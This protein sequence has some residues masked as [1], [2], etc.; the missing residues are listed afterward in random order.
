[1]TDGMDRRLRWPCTAPRAGDTFGV[2]GSQRTTVSD[3]WVS[4]SGRACP[5]PFGGF[6]QWKECPPEIGGLLQWK[7]CPGGVV[8]LL[9]WKGL[10][11]EVWFASYSAQLQRRYVHLGSN[12]IPRRTYSR[13]THAA[14]SVPC[15]T[16]AVW[17]SRMSFP[18]AVA[19]ASSCAPGLGLNVVLCGSHARKWTSLPT[20][21]GIRTAQPEMLTTR[22]RT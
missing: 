18:G 20:S 16:Y 12:R 10:P 7:A 13:T 4:S 1:M 14:Y 11:G 2:F 15:F 5:H 19:C 9:Q 21:A 17:C 6:F 22:C 8:G 3:V